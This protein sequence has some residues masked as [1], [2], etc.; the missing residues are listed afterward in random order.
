[1][2]LTKTQEKH[3]HDSRI[4]QRMDYASSSVNSL[5]FWPSK[6]YS[7]NVQILLVLEAVCMQNVFVYKQKHK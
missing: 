2:A 6:F 3:E 1:M 7:I 4:L 5:H